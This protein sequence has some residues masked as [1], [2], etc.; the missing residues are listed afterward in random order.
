M[1]IS[2]PRVVV[3]T[4]SLAFAVVLVGILLFS[5]TRTVRVVVRTPSTVLVPDAFNSTLTPESLTQACIDRC[6]SGGQCLQSN[7][8]GIVDSCV[9]CS[10]DRVL[11]PQLDGSVACIVPEY[12]CSGVPWCTTAEATTLVRPVDNALAQAA[13][14]TAA[15]NGTIPYPYTASISSSSNWTIL[16]A[17]GL[18]PSKASSLVNT[19]LLAKGA[20]LDAGSTLNPSTW[21]DDQNSFWN[22]SLPLFQLLRPESYATYVTQIKRTLCARTW[23]LQQ[24]ECVRP[25]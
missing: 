16:A 20:E 7:E 24:G 17:A 19:L 21:F 4:T 13:L 9:A 15:T 11:A 2:T 5:S 6:G 14:D 10:P 3:G 8:S 22:N 12:D 1:T 23:V 25:L 18:T